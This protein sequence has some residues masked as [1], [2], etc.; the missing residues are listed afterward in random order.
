MKI[1]PWLLAWAS[2]LLG[3][4]QASAQTISIAASPTSQSVAPGGSFNV[5]LTL[6]VPQGAGPSNVAAYDLYLITGSAN[7]GYFSIT[8]ATAT[9]P[10]NAFG[11]NDSAG[12]PLN[13]AA[14][15]GYVMNNLDQGFSGT[16]QTVPFANLQLET[17][18]L[19]LG[20]NVPAGTYTFQTSTTPTAGVYYSDVSDSGGTVYEVTAP[21]TFSITVVPEPSALVWLCVVLFG[22]G[23]CT[24]KAR[25]SLL[26]D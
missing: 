19:S 26:A 22:V 1:L 2:V 9:G 13:T 15:T 14:T 21:G 8:S 17:L 7:A 4:W 25:R 20:M 5:S 12:D 6:S 16:T 11:P 18:T 3:G 10:F 23:V 24:V